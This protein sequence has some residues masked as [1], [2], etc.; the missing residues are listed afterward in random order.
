MEQARAEAER[1]A[2]EAERQLSARQRSPAAIYERF[3]GAEAGT[4]T[5]LVVED[6]AMDP[7]LLTVKAE[8]TRRLAAEQEQEALRSQDLT[9]AYA[10]SA[11]TARKRDRE[12]L[13]RM[14]LRTRTAADSL[15]AASLAS[16]REARELELAARQR[17]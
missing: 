13:E 6:P 9:A 4:L 14:V 12:R 5:T 15:Q 10:D 16:A 17:W 7:A 2:A 11:A 8:S 1:L 3:L